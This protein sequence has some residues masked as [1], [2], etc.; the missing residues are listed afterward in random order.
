MKEIYTIGHSSHT[1]DYFLHLLRKFNINSVVDIRSVPF[2]KYVPNFNKNE[3]KNFLN[4]NH[5]Y[6]VYMAR[7]FGLIQEDSKLFHPDGYLDFNKLSETEFFIKGINRLKSGV[8]NGYKIAIMC[9]EK[10]PLDCHRSIL[11]SPI[12][13][14]EGY[15][16]VH[17]LP[18]GKRETHS[19]LEDRLLRLYFPQTPQ[20]N[21]FHVI[22]G[23]NNTKNLINLSYA[24][25][26]KDLM[27][28]SKITKSL[29]LN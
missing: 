8:D 23:E 28:K 10:D 18:D 24:L 13:V 22:E 3:I 17:I 16:V 27:Y 4:L 21:F 12:L 7:E 19:E 25:R 6:Y 2:S 15:S 11:I 9:A 29:K 26:N 5:I 1:S 20:Q 14:S